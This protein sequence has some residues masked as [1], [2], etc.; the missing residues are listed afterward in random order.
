MNLQAH[1]A[2]VLPSSSERLQFYSIE[3]DLEPI[4]LYTMFF[5]VFLGVVH[6]SRPS[7]P[8]R[9]EEAVWGPTQS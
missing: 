1:G 7:E 8:L 2:K 3:L 9:G 4:L 6:S 5:L